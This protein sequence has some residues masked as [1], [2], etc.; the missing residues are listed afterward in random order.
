VTLELGGKSPTIVSAS[1]DLKRAAASLVMAKALNA[2]QTCIA[3][4]YVLVHANHRTAFAQAF[5]HA[6]Q[7]QYPELNDTPDY[8]SLI[9]DRHFD[10]QIE[11]LQDARNQ[12][13]NILTPYWAP[14]LPDRHRRRLAPTLIVNATATMRV[15]QEEIFGPLLPVVFYDT[16]EAALEIIG[17]QG[18]P[19]ALYW[20]GQS[21]EEEQRILHETIAGGVTI[22]DCILHI[23]QA[24]LPF[25]GIGA[26]GYGSY[27]GEW[28]F[29]NFSK[30]KPIFR[31]SRWSGAH[32]MRAPY[33]KMFS[34]LARAMGGRG[35]SSP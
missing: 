18:R 19:L 32:L 13:A 26:S 3:P 30:L 20:F 10:R 9:S 35:Q 24:N 4:D 17:Q 7:T 29:R 23:A 6:L 15:M 25:G 14:N 1:A 28:G 22:N 16:L 31:Q 11:L 34:W 8:S 33:G 21:A 2:G 27:H 12:G 5:S